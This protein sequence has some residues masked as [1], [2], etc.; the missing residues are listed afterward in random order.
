MRMENK[1]REANEHYRQQYFNAAIADRIKQKV[2]QR[3]EDESDHVV[4]LHRVEKKP[5]SRWSVGRKLTYACAACVVLFGLF[6]GSAFVSPAMAEVAAKLPFLSKIFET[7]RVDEVLFNTLTDKGYKI[8]G[9]GYRVQG[10]LYYVSV[11]G[12]EEY[13]NKVKDDIKKVTEDIIGARGYDDYT[14]QVDRDTRQKV[15]TPSND[16]REKLSDIVMQVL[17]RSVGRLKEQNYQIETYGGGF[18]SPDAEEMTIDI[19]IPDKETRQDDIEKAIQADL[20]AKNIKVAEIKFHTVNLEKQAIEQKWTS[21]I[22]PV[23]WEGLAGKKEYKTT[24]F[25]YS[26]KDGKFT[27]IIKTSVSGNDAD[28]ADVARNIQATIR[29]FLNSDKL[30]PIVNNQPYEII[31]KDKKGKEI[32]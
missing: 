23:I 25:G 8:S 12:S 13:F 32:K 31:V 14:V 19:T 21:K 10:K 1:L 11:D 29:E 20:Q 28:A 18:A 30:V 7:K 4:S 6:L 5:K 22:L 3:I 16:P 9:I 26:F 17:D 15:A 2:H 24:G 27:I